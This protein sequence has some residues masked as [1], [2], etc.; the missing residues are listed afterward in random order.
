MVPRTEVQLGGFGG[1]GVISAGRIIGQA[2]ALYDKLEACFTQSYGPEARGGAAGSQV[3][4]STDPIHHPHLIEPTSMIIMSQGAYN[5]YVP[6]LATGGMLVIDDQL[7][8]LPENHRSDIKTYGIPATQIA[9]QAGSSR[10]AN[11]VMLGFWSAIVGVVSRDAIRQ[12]VAESVPAKM[13][14]MNLKVFDLG[15][16]KGLEMIRG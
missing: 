14:E 8:N 16:E 15:Y 11:T 4:I 6:S 9:E 3:I 2:A 5:K 1:Q 12:S 7:V 10:A 13:L